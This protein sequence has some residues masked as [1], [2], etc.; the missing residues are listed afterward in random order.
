MRADE[1]EKLE[2][3]LVQRTLALN[4]FLNDIYGKQ[5]IVKDKIISLDVVESSQ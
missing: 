4:A 3:G 2:G 5:Q 1:W